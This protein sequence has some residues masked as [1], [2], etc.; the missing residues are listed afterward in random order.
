[1]AE[2]TLKFHANG[3]LLLTGEYLVLEGAEALAV[4]LRVGQSLEVNSISRDSEQI[5][6]WE[7]YEDDHIWFK[8]KIDYK[9]FEILQATDNSIA[10]RLL[11]LLVHANRLNRNFL[12]ES[13]SYY[14]ITRL[15]FHR[16][17]GFGS[18]STLIHML[19]QWAMVDPFDLFFA[20]A[21]GSA[22]DIACVGAPS[23][24]IY[25][26]DK[27]RPKISSADFTPPFT[28]KLYLI[29][30]GNKQNSHSSVEEFKKSAVI[31]SE[32]IEN[33]NRITSEFCTTQYLSRFQELITEHE[34]LISSVLKTPPVKEILFPDFPGSVKSLGAWGGDFVMAASEEE[35]PVV[36]D[37]FEKKGFTTIFDFNALALL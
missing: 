21:N 16:N 33:M 25:K 14:V 7:A 35:S 32:I 12:N 18:S 20:V 17:W 1:M 9:N 27:K 31:S 22:Y 24:I 30:L 11:E 28:D 5:I 8:A 10:N 37:Y 3:K 23:P 4:P 34:Q 26:L 19:A 15:E 6:L 2:N 29:Y 36:K 13:C